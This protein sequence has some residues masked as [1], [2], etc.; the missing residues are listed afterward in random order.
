M[1]PANTRWTRRY[2]LRF[3]L[4]H[5]VLQE[6]IDKINVR[7]YTIK[8]ANHP[9]PSNIGGCASCPSGDSKKVEFN[10]GWVIIYQVKGSEIHFLGFYKRVSDTP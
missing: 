9:D 1:S 3:H 10:T 5:R 8:I 4:K 6:K 7:E 2:S